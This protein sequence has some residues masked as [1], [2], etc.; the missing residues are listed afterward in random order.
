MSMGTLVDTNV[1]SESAR[2]K[3]DGGVLAWMDEQR[4]GSLYLSVITIGEV[5]AGI[6]GAGD[7][8][9]RA[10]LTRWLEFDVRRAFLGRILVVDERIAQA[11]GTIHAGNRKQPVNVSDELIAATAH[12]NGLTVATR[13]IRDFERCG[14][15]TFNP[16]EFE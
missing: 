10:R 5:A 3:P 14:V 16:W 9:L 12:V 4:I 7:D 2:A 11:W 15:P 6:A 8:V 1:L 13:N